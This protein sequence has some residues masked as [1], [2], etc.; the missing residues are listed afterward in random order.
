MSVRVKVILIVSVV[1]LLY[2]VLNYCTQRLVVFPSFIQLERRE[3]E[4]D[5]QRCVQA[6]RRE[7]F[8]LDK[9]CYDW[10]RWDD[11]YRFVVD[12]NAEYIEANL[13]VETFR[14][15]NL[16]L[17]YVCSAKGKVVWGEIRDVKTEETMQIREFASAAFPENHPLLAHLSV[18]SS[19]A[20]VF[21]TEKGPMLISSRPITTSSGEGPIRGSL[22]MGRFLNRETVKTLVDQTRVTFHFWSIPDA[23]MPVKE[24]DAL[25]R[26]TKGAPVLISE[27]D[28]SM[29][30]TYTTFPD[31]QGTPAIL[32]RADIPRDVIAEGRAALRFAICS[33]MV[34]GSMVLLTILLLLERTVLSRVRHLGA[35]VSEIGAG[36]DLSAR[37]SLKG[38]DEL[39]LLAV[40]INLMLNGLE[41]AQR[42]LEKMNEC[43]LSFGSSPDENVNCLTA[44]CGELLGATCA[45]YNRLDNGL[46]CALGQWQTPADYNAMDKPEGHICYDVI[47][48]GGDQIVLV[49]D[50]PHS[51][52]AT[53][54]P[55][56]GR[57]KLQTYLGK[58]VR[59]NG[60][61]VGSLCVVYQEDRVPTEEDKKLMGIIAAALAVE[62]ERKRAEKALHESEKR[63]QSQLFQ[64]EKMAAI[65][66]LAAGVAHEINN[67]IGFVNSNLG[68]LG[69]FVDR[70]LMYLNKCEEVI[71]RIS[72]DGAN[73]S[74]HQCAAELRNVK[75]QLKL[76]FVIG[77]LKNVVAESLEGTERVR[78]IVSDLKGFAHADDGKMQY[79]NLNAG[80]DSTLN[81]VWNELKY[82]CDVKR[83]YGSIPDILCHPMQLNQVFMNILVNAAQA[84]E[85]RGEIAVRTWSE[86]GSV[87]VRISD[88][89]VGIP[90][91]NLSRIFE[92]FFTTK[93]VAKGT[94]L[95]LSIAY[96]IVK[97]HRGTI[98][99]ESEV[100]K[101]TSFTIKL[102][103]EGNNGEPDNN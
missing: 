53:S 89:G 87:C 28:D 79:A 43:F 67:P 35:S 75:D 71:Q 60:T 29:L 42:R 15:N 81:I 94:G 86:D 72:G 102:P 1:I 74:V 24:R 46:L 6:L 61:N 99:V 25:N 48:Q 16:N 23:S 70:I 68:T 4:K 97:K 41:Q 54:D 98:E 84:I 9:F 57:Y 73:E 66:Q 58:A 85:N 26:I 95:G 8:H 17:I 103:V 78:K 44:L 20:G 91:E 33:I 12:R 77:D 18:A 50:L 101:G 7:V 22:I 21:M 34:V 100:G 13:V 14:G 49:R 52:Y 88:T 90:R 5:I 45:L 62:E 11:T 56:V 96:D 19:I 37:V 69:K 47:L 30:H 3:A 80:L 64:Q 82:K 93:E 63:W 39:C 83:E 51:K 31:I 27:Y 36:G 65:G 32:I 92:P 10:A 76:D 59:C 38:K 2:A 55:N 40:D